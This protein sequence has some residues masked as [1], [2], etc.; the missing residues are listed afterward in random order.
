MQ[1]KY[2]NEIYTCIFKINNMSTAFC[3]QS[4]TALVQLQNH[5]EMFNYK[6]TGTDYYEIAFE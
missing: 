5:L 2:L 1:L 4:D 6:V 3:K